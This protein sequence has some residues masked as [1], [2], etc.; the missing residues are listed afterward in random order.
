MAAAGA[1]LLVLAAAPLV[2]LLAEIAAGWEQALAA[3]GSA[4]PL[5]LLLRSLALALAVTALSLTFGIPLGVLVGRTDARG[6]GLA[7]L[8]HAFPVFLPPFLLALGWFQVFG[9][10]G[11]AGSAGTSSLLF[12]ETGVVLVLAATLTPIAT[13]LVAMG[14]Q[15]VDPSLEEAARVAARPLQVA[16]RIL[17][18]AAAPA[19]ALAAVAIFSL[20]LSELGVPMFLRVDSFP[21]AVFARLGGVDYAPGEAFALVLPLVPVALA[22]L[23]FE[24]RFVGTRALAVLGLRSGRREGLP[25]GRWRGPASAALWLV[26]GVSLTP[27]AALV[28]RAASGRGFAELGSWLGRAPWNSLWTGSAAATLI[29]AIGLVVGHGVARGAAGARA[30]DALSVLGFVA[31]A[32]ILGVGLI[33]VWNRPALQW[34]Y[35][36]AG[37]L[38]VGYV[39][40]YA[41]IGV[42]TIGSLVAQTPV[43]LEE[44]AATVG[45]GFWRRLSRILVPLHARGIAFAWLLALVFCLRDL[46]L[47]VLYYPAGGEPMTVR[48]FTLEANGPEPVVAALAV[49][50]VAMTAA[51]L[52]ASGWLLRRSVP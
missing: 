7:V 15:A 13:V 24:R 26:A 23:G 28:W 48:I 34:V 46:E 40:R 32:G 49:T 10:R 5:V 3:L 29:V 45:A 4:R 21:A 19:I 14:L 8:L 25:L 22:L 11:L 50:Q 20:S 41:V 39:A 12:G 31:P 44:A 36:S 52:G 35:G 6:R 27:V 43:H 16:A 18:P 42:R 37:I 47:A 9:A 1:A 38:V 30:L 51:L 17:L 33:A 2:A